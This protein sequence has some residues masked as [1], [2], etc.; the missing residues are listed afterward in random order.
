MHD[1][2][3]AFGAT[4]VIA[5]E[6][7]IEGKKKYG[8]YRKFCFEKQHIAVRLG[9]STSAVCCWTVISNGSY[10]HLNNHLAHP[11]SLNSHYFFSPSHLSLSLSFF[12]LLFSEPLRNA[13]R[14]A[15]SD[16][17]RKTTALTGFPLFYRY[18]LTERLTI[19]RHRRESVNQESRTRLPKDSDRK[20]Q[21]I[22]DEKSQTYSVISHYRDETL[23]CATTS[24]ENGPA[25]IRLRRIFLAREWG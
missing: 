11:P 16:D 17:S 1:A 10:G 19:I 22:T 12:L 5:R 8:S 15:R 4:R 13:I 7:G 3:H 25:K 18:Q 14:G 9:S 6:R 2:F 20:T 21:I 23:Y 24:G